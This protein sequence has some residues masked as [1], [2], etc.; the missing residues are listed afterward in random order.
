MNNVRVVLVNI[1]TLIILIGGGIAAFY[2]YNQL[3]NYISTD[4]A[5]VDGQQITIAPA[6]GGQLTE[7]NGR[8]GKSYSAGDR[9]GTVGGTALTFPVNGTIVQQNA[10][11]NTFVAP[12]TPL[13]RAYDLNNLFITANVNETDI[14][15][16]KVGQTVDVYVDAFPGTTLTGKV[17]TKGLATAATFS[18]LPA[19]NTTGNYTKVTQVI[20]VTISIDSYNGLALVPG[21]NASVRI[22]R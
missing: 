5:R 2:Y 19:S 13:A 4:N 16:V 15:D 8:V 17:A 18:L 20:P 10:V 11:P 21:M 3:Q 7:W 1:I 9:V 14:N 22:H 12:G 6:T